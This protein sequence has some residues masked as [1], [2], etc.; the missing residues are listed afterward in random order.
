MPI[1]GRQRHT[2]FSLRVSGGIGSAGAK[3]DLSSGSYRLSGLSG[4]ASFDMGG[5]PVDNLIVYGHLGGLAFAPS[6]D[7]LG[8]GT[9]YLG[10]L[11]AGARY[12]F[13]PF[14]WY[15][16]GTLALALM[17]ITNA[18][19]AAENAR[20]GV[21]LELETGKEWSAGAESEWNVGLGV[22]FS[23]AHCPASRS[24]RSPNSAWQ[25]LGL[26][27]VFSLAYN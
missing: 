16:G 19:G 3:R 13:M 1:V 26:S 5:T 18:K 14:D 17:A 2:G 7:S 12:H 11:G 22:R 4:R 21:G 10:L 9:A 20:P 23:Y 8:A 27:L 25:V 24:V 6:S 15:A